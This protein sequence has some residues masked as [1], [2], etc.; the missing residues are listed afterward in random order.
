MFIGAFS[1]SDVKVKDAQFVKKYIDN[2]IKSLGTPLILLALPQAS[3]AS[4]WYKSV[5]LGAVVALP[6]Y[7]YVNCGA[8]IGTCFRSVNPKP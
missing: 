7:K 4:V 2:A 8:S 5:N 1:T 3:S 6:R